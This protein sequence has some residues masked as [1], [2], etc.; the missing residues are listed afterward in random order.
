MATRMRAGLRAVAGV[1]LALALVVGGCGTTDPA[2][3]PPSPATTQPPRA[4]GPASAATREA[5]LAA[6]GGASL[7]VADSPIPF[8]PAEAATLAAAPRTVYQVTLPAEPNN[9]FI[10]VYELEDEAAAIA[11]SKEQQAYLLSGP[12]RVQA[13]LGTE[14]VLQQLGSTVILYSWLPEASVD[15]AAPRIAE[16]LRGVG[17][18]FEVRD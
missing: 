12:G 4:V 18:A 15:P 13:P 2:A 9:G 6:L 1:S 17:T 3:V 11:A 16:T 5:L 7:L 10:V 8:R 14:H